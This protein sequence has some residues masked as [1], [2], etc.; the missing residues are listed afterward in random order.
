[1]TEGC[2]P[3]R[4]ERPTSP[5][6]DGEAERS[7]DPR[8]RIIMRSPFAETRNHV[9]HRQ[10]Q[11]RKSKNRGDPEPSRH[12]AQF[13]VVLFDRRIFRL[14]RHSADWAVARMILFDLRVHRTGIIRLATEHEGWVRLEGHAAFQASAGLVRLHSRTHWA[15]VRCLRRGRHH[16]VIILRVVMVPPVRM[17]MCHLISM[18]IV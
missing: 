2:P 11:D 4:E 3:A 18:L 8:H 13:R 16:C 15:V 6:H 17:I 12:V 14:Q 9:W 7:L 10:Q 5:P 1:M